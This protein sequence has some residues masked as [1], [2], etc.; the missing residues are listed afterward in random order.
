M[1]ATA[2]QAEQLHESGRRLDASYHA[3]DGVQALRFIQHYAVDRVL[4]LIAMIQDAVADGARFYGSPGADGVDVEAEHFGHE[5]FH[6]ATVVGM[7]EQLD[8]EGLLTASTVEKDH[9]ISFGPGAT[10]TL[11]VSP[12]DERYVLVS[13]DADRT[14]SQPTIPP[15][16]ELVEE[17]APDGVTFR[18]D[19]QTRVIRADNEDSFQGP[20]MEAAP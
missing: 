9:E 1:R 8:D 13:R 12:D 5:W 3:S 20:V 10:V 14:S 7:G 19:G 2:T 4:A 11:L 15:G 16:W 17:P 6:S 18:L